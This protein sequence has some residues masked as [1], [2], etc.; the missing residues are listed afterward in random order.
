[1]SNPG[2]TR[3]ILNGNPYDI[4]DQ[5]TSPTWGEQVHDY[6]IALNTFVQGIAG[7]NDVINAQLQ[8]S[9]PPTSFQ[10]LNNVQIDPLLSAGGIVTYNAQVI[11][12]AVT[13]YEQGQFYAVYKGSNPTNQKFEIALQRVGD[14]DVDFNITDAGQIQI[15]CVPPTGTWDTLN[16]RI[17]VRAFDL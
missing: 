2:F 8:F 4:P 14:A 16:V 10:D 3:I 1:M 5:S 13:S 17:N 7:E 15:S 12:S 6:L 11:T 9:V